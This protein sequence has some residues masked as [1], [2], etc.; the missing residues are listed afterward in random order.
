MQYSI[1]IKAYEDA[2]E[3]ESH[4]LYF[5]TYEDMDEA[6]TLLFLFIKEQSLD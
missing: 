1:E 6:L 5:D 3:V 4:L 2:D